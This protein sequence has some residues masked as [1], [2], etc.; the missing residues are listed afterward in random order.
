MILDDASL[1]TD[2]NP[3]SFS[4]AGHPGPSKV[5]REFADKEMDFVGAVGHNNVYRKR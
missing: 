1:Y 2:Y 4:F 5:A 3:V